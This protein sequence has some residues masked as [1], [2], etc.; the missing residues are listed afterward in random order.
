MQNMILEPLKVLIVG[1]ANEELTIA[2]EAKTTKAAAIGSE[3]QPAFEPL[4]FDLAFTTQ[5]ISFYFALVDMTEV[6]FACEST[7]Q[8][9]FA[10]TT[11][12]TR[13]TLYADCRDTLSKHFSHRTSTQASMEDNR[14]LNC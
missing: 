12:L 1:I 7:T 6:E 11:K 13:V 10:Y 8:V 3:C 2:V 14:L 5:Q 9:L 4:R